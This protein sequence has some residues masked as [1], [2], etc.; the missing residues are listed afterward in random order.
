[1]SGIIK[2]LILVSAVQ[3][4]ARDIKLEAD[5]NGTYLS[6]LGWPFLRISSRACALGFISLG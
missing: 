5:L 2:D 3:D 1:M 4:L 6:F